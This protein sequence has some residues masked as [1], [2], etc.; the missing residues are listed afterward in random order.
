MSRKSKILAAL[1]ALGFASMLVGSGS[2]EQSSGKSARVKGTSETSTK[3]TTTVK[4]SKS[5]TSDRT[6]LNSSRSNR[7]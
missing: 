4:S 3:R 5:N 1:T 6:N 2:A 7:Y